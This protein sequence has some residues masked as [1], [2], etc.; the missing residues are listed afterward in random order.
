MTAAKG[1]PGVLACALLVAGCAPA[2]GSAAARVGGDALEPTETS[3]RPVDC[4]S[5]L[6]TVIE[7]QRVGD[8]AGAINAELDVLGDQ[9]SYEYRVFA[10]YASIKVISRVDPGGACPDPLE[11]NVEPAA[12]ELA[13]R[14]GFCTDPSP[15]PAPEP[16]WMCTY[17][18]TYDYDWHDDVVCSNGS[19]AHRPYLREWDDFVTE[20]EI[21]ESAREYELQLNAR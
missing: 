2:A 3:A 14:D 21:M 10:D 9:C 11:F 13:R 15:E 19:E 8:T 6:D 7:R 16:S 17:E 5:L 4:R 20:D 12:V 18:P 1:V